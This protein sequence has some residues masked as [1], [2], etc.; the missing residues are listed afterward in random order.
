KRRAVG[1]MLLDPEW[2]KWAD[3]EIARQCGVS[4]PFVATMRNELAQAGDTTAED[5]DERRRYIDKHGIETTMRRRRGAPRRKSQQASDENSE[6]EKENERASPVGGPDREEGA[7]DDDRF[8]REWP[9]PDTSSDA[10][11]DQELEV[12]REVVEKLLVEKQ[13]L[14]EKIDHL[15]IEIV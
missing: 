5:E 7:G 10:G 13:A 4:H 2:R 12:R 9:K 11:S 1:R 14:R 3:R 8:M 15:N 6:T